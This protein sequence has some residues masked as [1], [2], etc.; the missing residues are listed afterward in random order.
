MKY[1]SQSW[2][3]AVAAIL[4]S[5]TDCPVLKSFRAEQSVCK[6]G[7]TTS[8]AIEFKPGNAVLLGPT[9]SADNADE[10]Q[11]AEREFS[12]E[13]PAVGFS[14]R[15][16][17]ALAVAQGEKSSHEAFLLGEITFSGDVEILIRERETFS[18]LE[19]QLAP[20]IGETDFA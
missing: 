18:W 19:K 11:S 9:F 6:D 13:I 5:T 2:F 4:S 14:Q 1:L 10:S 12:Q 3:E 7:N 15:F 8:W 17:T 20:V 16:S